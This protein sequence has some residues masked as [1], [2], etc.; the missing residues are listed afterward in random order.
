MD[1][2][3]QR[4]LNNSEKQEK[5]QVKKKTVDLLPDADSN[6]QQLQVT[7][8]SHNA[9]LPLHCRCTATA[10]S[11][12]DVVEAS[13]KR[14]VHLA[15]QW[16]KHRAPLL[17]EHRRLR[18]LCTNQDVGG[19]VALAPPPRPQLNQLKQPRP[20]VV[21]LLMQNS[22]CFAQKYIVSPQSY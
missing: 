19:P 2:L 20:L 11:S 5:M 22:Q 14:L 6:L 4:E 12:Q 17:E 8:V 9:K 18:A 15:T 21:T 13:V 1:E 16:E 7:A 10:V 3:K